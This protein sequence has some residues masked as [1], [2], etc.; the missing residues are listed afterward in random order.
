MDRRETEE[1]IVN[2][3]QALVGGHILAVL[4]IA[5]LPI[6]GWALLFG[7]ASAAA[8]PG[9]VLFLAAAALLVVF[10]FAGVA[11]FDDWWTGARKAR[12]DAWI[13]AGGDQP[14]PRFLSAREQEA[15][16]AW[17]RGHAEW[18]EQRAARR[19]PGAK[20]SVR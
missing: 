3:A 6:V 7:L 10:I 14:T 16:A 8:F 17:E 11:M 2:A 1:V 5:A 4:L 20:E 13:A 9:P 15:K 12:R 19:R 18:L